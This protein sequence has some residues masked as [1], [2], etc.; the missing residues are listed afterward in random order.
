[1]LGQV[2]IFLFLQVIVKMMSLISELIV[3]FE[4]T[5]IQLISLVFE[6]VFISS[7]FQVALKGIFFFVLVYI[8]KRRLYFLQNL[9]DFRHISIFQ[10]ALY[11]LHQLG[12]GIPGIVEVVLVLVILMV[13]I[14]TV[15]IFRWVCIAFP[16]S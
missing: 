1:L 2:L 4:K 9:T 7:F 11:G 6:T 15:S 3:R 12:F 10:L 5:T 16:L 14:F 8:V 13:L